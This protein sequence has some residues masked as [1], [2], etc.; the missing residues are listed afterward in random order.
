MHWG[1]F[2]LTDEPMDAPPKALAK[3]LSEQHIEYVH[4][5]VPQHGETLTIELTHE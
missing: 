2:V 5:Q 3:A 1:T 4:F